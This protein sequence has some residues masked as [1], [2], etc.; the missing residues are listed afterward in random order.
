MQSKQFYENI[1]QYNSILTYLSLKWKLNMDLVL[2][3]SKY[4]LING[5]LYHILRMVKS[6]KKNR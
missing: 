5:E 3:K 2:N 4:F 1:C 6:L